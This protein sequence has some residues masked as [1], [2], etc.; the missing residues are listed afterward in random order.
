MTV[1]D[2]VVR[3]ADDAPAPRRRGAGLLARTLLAAAGGVAMYFAFP[4]WDLAAL[5][6]LG[7]ASLSLATRGVRFRTGLWLGLVQGLCFFLP[8]LSWTGIYVGS[9]PWYA[10]SVA[11]SLYVAVLGGALAVTAR[12]RGW[13]LWAAAL[14]VGQEALRGRWPLG[15]F[16]WGR[17][18]FS[19][20]EGPFTALAAYGGVP[21]VSFGVAL[22][23]TL[24][25]AA[26]LASARAW[27]DSDDAARRAGS[28]RAAAV[29]VV[30]TLA[31]PVVGTV[32]R[33]PLAGG[34][35]TEGGPTRT[36]A[37]VQGNVPR[38]GLDFNEQRRAVLDNHVRETQDLAAQVARGEVA[39]P[40][41]VIWPENSSDIDPYLN[42]DAAAAIDRAARAIGAPILVGAVVSGPGRFLSNTAIV[43]DPETGPGE[44]YVKR[45]P[46]PLAEY[47]PARS[48]FRF[49]SDKV[50]LVRADF[51]AGSDVGTLDMAGTTV[52]DVI[53]FEVAYDGLVHDTVVGGATMLVVQTNNAT[54][55]FSD[56]SPQQLAMGRLRA[57]EAGRSVV[58]A[59]TSGISAIIAPDGSLVRSSGL[60]TPATFVE[61]IAQRDGTTLATR[62][63]AWPEAALTALGLGATLLVVGSGLRR[64]RAGSVSGSSDVGGAGD[65]RRGRA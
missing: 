59:S 31:V 21:L 46:V 49:F 60:F 52:G 64:R 58:M 3:P 63:G 65:T 47:V 41:L 10:L 18:G 6:V 55:G 33:W 8:L 28:L 56:E 9:F 16:P 42:D 43:W 1:T 57:V 5:A 24:L 50:D 37:V 36:V 40:D 35:L 48:F 62:L 15:G 26:V 25:A 4:G 61:D 13:W 19:Q 38:A 12:L 11:E 30:G 27:R 17:L 22:T 45:H 39:Q 20:A 32:A 44:T 2:P 29:L 54:F 23:G 51:R 14:W 53:C 34:S 7:P